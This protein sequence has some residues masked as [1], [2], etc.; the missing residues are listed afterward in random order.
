MQGSRTI[1]IIDDDPIERERYRTMLEAEGFAVV[2][3]NNGAEAILWFQ[4]G[5]A[6]LILLD[7]GMPVIDGRSF[8]EYHLRQ[9]G[10]RDIPVLV[11]SSRLDDAGVREIF[12]RLGV[13]RLLQ[14]PARGDELVSAVRKLLPKT[15]SPEVPH[16]QE[17]QTAT[18]RQDPRV[19]F[20]V[21]LR[22]RSGFSTE[23]SGTLCDLSSGGLGMYLQHR[24]PSTDTITVT[25]DIQGL[26]VTLQGF[27]H[28]TAESHTPMGFRHGMRFSEKQEDSFPLYMYS[29]FR[30][31]SGATASL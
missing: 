28:W 2:E 27:V 15:S 24:I 21:P 4:R 18:Q 12:L 16:A 13:D 29:F 31:H 26:S 20:A 17:P 23:T 11:L 6:N 8:L 30:D 10:L 9:P 3:A 19:A 22:V 25:L 5:T 1:L 7:L 14:K